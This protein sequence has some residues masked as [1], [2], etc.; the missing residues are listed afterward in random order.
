MISFTPHP[1]YPHAVWSKA[2]AS[3]NGS[4]CVEVAQLG[5]RLGVRDSKRP[6]GD[7][8][9][10]APDSFAGFTGRITGCGA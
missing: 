3:G 8:L 6:M 2:N 1:Q 5:R 7:V 4:D 10:F 9:E